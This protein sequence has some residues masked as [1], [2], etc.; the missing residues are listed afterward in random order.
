MKTCEKER[1]LS[2]LTK[3]LVVLLSL[4]AIFL[5]G[6]IVTYVSTA[7]NYKAAYEETNDDLKKLK[8]SNTSYIKQL[9]AKKNEMEEMSDE[10]GDEIAALEADKLR[11]A[12]ELKNAD[13]AKIAMAEKVQNL[14]AAALKFESTVGGMETSLKET[15]ADLDKAR[16]EGIKLSKNLN[17]ITAS[18][19]EK[20]AQLESLDAEK[21]RLLEEKAQIES[22]SSSAVVFEPVTQVQDTAMAAVEPMSEVSIDGVISEVDGSLVTISIGAADGVQKGMILHVIRN[23]GFVCDIKITEVD[24]EMAAGTTQLVQQQPQAGDTVSTA[25]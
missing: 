20:M 14:A 23:E 25:W 22:G 8:R 2:T 7:T 9:E 13:R 24:D 5:C 4:F 3:I 1:V 10:L 11:I 16:A 17:E 19:E 15:R 21:K 6:T 18:L 12:G